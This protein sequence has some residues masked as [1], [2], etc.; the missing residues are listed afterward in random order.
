MSLGKSTLLG[1]KGLASLLQR[2]SADTTFCCRGIEVIEDGIE[3]IWHQ[4]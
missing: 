2:C 3:K 1:I 4:L